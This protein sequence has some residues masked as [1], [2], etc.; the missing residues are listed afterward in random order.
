MRSFFIAICKVLGIFCIYLGIFRFPYLHLSVAFGLLSGHESNPGIYIFMTILSF[1]IS[2]AFGLFLIFKAELIADKLQV[3]DSDISKTDFPIFSL[4]RIGIIL[5]GFFILLEQIPMLF[6][7]VY[8]TMQRPEL[9]NTGLFFQ[10]SI[11]IILAVFA[12][13][14]SDLITRIVL[15]AKPS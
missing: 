15:R 1:I 4:T 10:T 14:K 6:K 8:E 9:F 13:M 7:L 5:I 2:T 12:F 3:E 11:A